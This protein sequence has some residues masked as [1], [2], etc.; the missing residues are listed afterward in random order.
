ML[1][2][3]VLPL[4]ERFPG[5]GIGSRA[6]ALIIFWNGFT[7]LA[8]RERSKHFLVFLEFALAEIEIG[9]GSPPVTNRWIFLEAILELRRRT[10]AE[11]ILEYVSPKGFVLAR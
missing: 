10:F 9:L 8:E 1:W 4:K 5:A 11:P 7:R 2:G 6:L 3:C